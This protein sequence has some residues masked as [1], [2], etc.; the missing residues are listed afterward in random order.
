MFTGETPDICE[1]IDIKFYD[2]EWYFDQKKIEING[3]GRRLA[4]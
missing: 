3:S 1:W 4:R 2:Q